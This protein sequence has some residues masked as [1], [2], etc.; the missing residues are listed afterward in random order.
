MALDWL[1]SIV[2][3][4]PS[5]RDHGGALVALPGMPFNGSRTAVVELIIPV[6]VSLN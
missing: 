5:P 1:L 4:N 2:N 6:F 3:S